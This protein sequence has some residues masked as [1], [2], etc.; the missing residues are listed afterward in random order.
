MSR[1]PRARA[2]FLLK[3]AFCLSA[4]DAPSLSN[5][6]TRHQ[7]MQGFTLLELLIAL[8]LMALILVLLFSGLHLA[9]R[10]WEG[11]EQA[12]ARHDEERIARRVLSQ[13]LYQTRPVEITQEGTK[14]T[15]FSGG[16]RYLELAAP[17]ADRIGIGGLYVL[18]FSLA[19]LDDQPA[20]IMT[21][22]LLHPDV[23]SGSA[24]FPAFVSMAG[25]ALTA[26]DIA[27]AEPDAEKGVYGS[28]VLLSGLEAFDIA[29]FGTLK[30]AD[31]ADWTREWLDQPIL[32]ERVR[33][34]IATDSRTWA[35]LLVPLPGEQ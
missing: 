33:I 8:S 10:S 11:V 7:P 16:E 35:D 17:L 6:L 30:G 25:D 28:R 18:R 23:L 29:Y 2:P 9:S 21:Y 32:P 34:R 4:P 20:L 15:V 14:R 5:R 22:W 26:L 13:S 3:T 19:S 24:E 31:D 1:S 27:D 12:V